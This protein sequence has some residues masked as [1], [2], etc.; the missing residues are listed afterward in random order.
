MHWECVPGS[1]RSKVKSMQ[2]DLTSWFSSGGLKATVRMSQM[3]SDERGLWQAYI[4]QVGRSESVQ[5]SV[6]KDTQFE[7]NTIWHLEPVQLCSHNS[8]SRR[9]I[10]ELQNKPGGGTEDGL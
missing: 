2:A 6:Y 8:G 7:S 9:T 1:R 4:R 3:I 10:W 5:T